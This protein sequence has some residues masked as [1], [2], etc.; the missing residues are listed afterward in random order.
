MDYKL[1]DSEKIE[2]IENCIEENALR[3]G[4][5]QARAISEF[6]YF[7][8]EMR[9]Y[10]TFGDKSNEYGDVQ[11]KIDRDKFS[12][13]NIYDYFILYRMYNDQWS[14]DEEISKNLREKIE[15]FL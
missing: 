3:R 1:D 14:L 13:Q 8:R 9:S 15:G 11:E 4:G 12:S 10:L 2:I 6:G 5:M 7:I